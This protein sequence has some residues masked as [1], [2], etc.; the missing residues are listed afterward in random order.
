MATAPTSRRLEPAP[1]AP[2]GARHDGSGTS[3]SLFSSVAEAVELCLF[4]EGG[5]ET[6]FDLEQG[7]ACVWQGYLRGVAPGQRY[8]FRV[9]GPWDPP[10]GARCNAAKLLLDPYARA[11]AGEVQWNPAVYGH[12]AD[13]PDTAD[14]SDSAP[15]VPRSVVIPAAFDW[16]EDKRPGYG[17]ADSVFY[18]V[19]VKGFTKLH[20]EVP[21]QLRG[22]YAGVAHPAAVAHL[23]RLGVTAVELLPVHQ[24]VHDAQLVARGLRN[25]WGYQSIGYFAPHNGYSSSGDGGG[26][27]DEFRQ[28]VR[29]LHAAGL[30]VI[31]DVVFNHTAEGDQWGPTLCFRAIDNAAYYRLA[32]DR[33]RYVDDTGVGNTVDLH[34]PQPLRLVMDSLRYWVEEMHVDG[35]RFD[36]AAALGRGVSDFDP[37]GSFLEAI[38]Q[39]PVLSEV[40]LI[41]EPWDTGSGG[42]DLGQ[43]PAGW[44]EWNGK[45]RDTVRDF[46]RGVEGA[47]PGLATRISG[48]RDLFGHGGRRPT[49]SVNIATVHDGFTL[50]DLVSYNAKHNEANGENNRDG[51]D[52]NRSWNCG[53]EGPTDSADV[54]ALRARQRRNFLATLMLSE[55]APLLLGGDE[56]AR[57]QRGNNNAYCQDDELSWFDWAAATANADL[58]E[59][60]ARLCRLREQ[61]PVFRRR[62]FFTGTPAHEHERDDLDWFRPDGLAMTGQD[63]GAVYARSVTVALSGATGDD[64]RPDDPFLILLNAWWEPLDFVIPA[65]LR[66]L[67]W[68]LEVDTNTPGATGRTI[69]SSAPVTLIGRSLVL[70]R[71]PS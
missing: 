12:V 2:L 11:V 51:S 10:S 32:D 52:D 8:G 68:Q 35:F 4:D 55:G 21:E 66:D 3:F 25:Y 42:Y 27:I 14:G 60:T 58:I 1:R 50:A 39:D 24:F 59:F 18:E 17:M 71:S 45:F 48:S 40:K 57:T 34:Q 70:L 6:R 22:T 53:V 5:A 38:G 37:H 28:M 61:H 15:Y 64:T 16:G 54:L 43:F 36:L 31:L 30:E 62:Q 13:D 23:K 41:A 67:A 47:L 20:P 46:W 19:H 26:Q 44:S 49:A 33:S 56:F 65:S 7:E 69:E 63:W 29:A 9:H